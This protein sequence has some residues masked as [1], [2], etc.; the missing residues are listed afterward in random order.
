MM[1]RSLISSA[2]CGITATLL[3]ACSSDSSTTDVTATGVIKHYADIAEAVYGDSLHTAKE[4]KTAIDAFL[5]APTE[6]NL[7]KAKTA[8]IAA[9]AP[10]QQ[11]EVYRF[12]NAIVDDWEGKVNAWPLDEGLIDYVDSDYGTES[13]VNSLYTANIVGSLALNVN[14]EELNITNITPALL[15]ELHEADGVEANVAT[16][17]HAIEFLLWGQ[18]LNGT[19]PGAGNRPATDFDTANCTNGNCDRRRDYLLAATELLISDLEEM[20][21]N[22]REN[23][24]ARKAVLAQTDQQGLSTILTGMGSLAYGELG[25]ERTK[26][27][28]MLHDPEEEHDCF[29]DNTHYS[30][31]YDAKGIENVY[32]GKYQRVDGSWVEGPSL[33]ALVQSKNTDLD[34]TMKQKL[35]TTDTAAMAMVNAAKEGQTFDVLIGMGNTAGNKLVQDF[36]DSLVDETRTIEN[37]ITALDLSDV[38][39][40]GS[41]SLD[42]PASVFE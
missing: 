18:D 9:R 25:G 11:S 37:I 6:E 38:A 41:D 1:K 28:L 26:L 29:S 12:G 23:G 5:A 15:Q 2:V 24:A 13:D 3:V 42:N 16:G 20:A 33:S 34:A 35:T 36:V 40:E 39:L 31:Y 21:A 17:Y 4:L 14:G 8:W 7:T 32:L 27:G 22:W 10:Y 19:N 30:H